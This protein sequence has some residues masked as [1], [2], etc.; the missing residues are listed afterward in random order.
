[1]TTTPS[2]GLSDR[3]QSLLAYVGGEGYPC[4]IGAQMARG[5]ALPVVELLPT[6]SQ[7]ERAEKV[8]NAVDH[9][10]RRRISILLYPEDP[11]DINDL[12]ALHARTYPGVVTEICLRDLERLRDAGQLTLPQPAPPRLSGRDISL[13][14]DRTYMQSRVPPCS[15][16]ID[17]VRTFGVPLAADLRSSQQAVGEAVRELI[18]IDPNIYPVYDGQEVQSIVV[19]PAYAG[20]RGESTA[21]RPHHEQGDHGRRAS[22]TALVMNFL[23]DVQAALRTAAG[24]KA[25][26]W[27]D[28]MPPQHAYKATQVLA[29]LERQ[30]HLVVE[31]APDIFAPLLRGLMARS[32]QSGLEPTEPLQAPRN[33]KCPCGSTKKFKHCCG[34]AR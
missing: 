2:A 10:V 26:E 24:Q 22:T 5:D 6:D 1:M 32:P 28:R 15:P 13:H 12:A 34:K 31:V 33:A 30:R 8:I 9:L 25:V 19:S 23:P 7:S 14:I 29:G 17:M 20:A 21:V 27:F 11:L 4:P 3:A 16:A 18:G